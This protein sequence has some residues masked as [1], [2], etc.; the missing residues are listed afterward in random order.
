V[1]IYTLIGVT[2]H[3]RGFSSVTVQTIV[4]LK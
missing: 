1:K 2:I 3:F 4:R